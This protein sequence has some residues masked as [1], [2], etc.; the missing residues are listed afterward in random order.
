M[1]REALAVVCTIKEFHPY[2]YGFPF[3]VITDH[4]PLTSLKGIKDT[5]GW[6][7]RWLM[8]L[9]EFNFE[10]KYKK[11]SQ[12]SNTDALSRQPPISTLTCDS[13]LLASTD[14]LIQSQQ[15]DPQLSL[16]RDHVEQ[17]TPLP[18]CPPGLRKCFIHD[19]ILC[20]SYK[21]SSTGT[22]RVQ[23]VVPDVLKDTIMRETH[24][25]GHLGIKKTLDTIRTRFY[26]PGYVKDVEDWV[27][28]CS[29]CQ[30]HK[31]PQPSFPAPM[32]T[33]TATYPFE[34]ISWDIKGPLPPTPRGHQYILVVTD[35]FNRRVEA[36]PLPNTTANTLA[37][38]LMNEV[39][40]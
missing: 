20:C 21:K 12:H 8:F 31:G 27:K 33:I 30:K 23:I 22:V 14:E 9:Q 25:L 2:L 3:T 29:E 24:G 7:T 35:L 39:H 10:I 4:N 18:K 38:I 15:E 36:F 6:L 37:T 28:Q 34:K 19:G 5:G 16:I 11:G 13:T 1:E 32:G 26:W 17:G 40:L